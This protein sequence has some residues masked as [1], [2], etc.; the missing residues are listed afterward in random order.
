MKIVIDT[1]I[2]VSGVYFGGYPAKIVDAWLDKSF[3]V[4]V[5][6][7]II[8][9]YIRA[10]DYLSSKRKPII[11]QDWNVL[12][13]RI[14]HIISEEEKSRPLCRDKHDDKFLYCAL[15][16]KAKFLITGDKDL[17]EFKNP[18]SFNIVSP[19]QFIHEI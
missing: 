2:L 3:L 11:D 13:P 10:L 5:T 6:P 14:C 17:K 8:G 4:F 7:S 12:L 19:K 1:N 9:E 16:S 18:F 15:K